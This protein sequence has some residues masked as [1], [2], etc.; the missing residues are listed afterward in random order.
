MSNYQM[1]KASV[2]NE[3]Q[4]WQNTFAESDHSWEE[5]IITQGYFERQGRR[6]GLLK[7]FRAEGI[8]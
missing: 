1:K 6:Y 4:D 7:E 3:A 5:M 8:C 2:R